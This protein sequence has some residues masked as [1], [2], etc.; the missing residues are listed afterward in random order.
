M[1]LSVEGGDTCSTS[2]NPRTPW[3]RNEFSI[4]NIT[5]SDISGCD[6]AN[7]L[8]EGQRVR[9]QT[10]ITYYSNTTCPVCDTNIGDADCVACLHSSIG[11]LSARVQ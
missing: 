8:S 7:D 3:K 5:Y 6:I 11:Q 1:S 4:L 2:F 9:L 10:N